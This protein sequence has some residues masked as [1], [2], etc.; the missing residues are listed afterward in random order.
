MIIGVPKESYPDERRVAL[1]PIVIP[2]LVNAGFEVLVVPSKMLF[3][4]IDFAR[5]KSETS[6]FRESGLGRR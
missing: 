5:L 4:V 6:R 1:V 3:R 2:N